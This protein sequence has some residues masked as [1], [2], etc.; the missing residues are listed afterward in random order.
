MDGGDALGGAALALRN[1]FTDTRGALAPP[2]HPAP[3]QHSKRW[4]PVV[5]TSLGDPPSRHP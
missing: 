4:Q 1:R 5:V 2:G 3:E